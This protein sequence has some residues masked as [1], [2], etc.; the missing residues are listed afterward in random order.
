MCVVSRAPAALTLG[1]RLKSIANFDSYECRGRNRA[2]G[3]KLSEHGR[4]NALDIKGIKLANGADVALTDPAVSTERSA[5]REI[6]D[7]L[8]AA[9]DRAGHRVR[10]RT[11]IVLESRR[12]R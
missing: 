4:A 6:A 7:I 1:A 3:G 12:R 5:L 11:I 8:K 10:Q 9:R 2:T